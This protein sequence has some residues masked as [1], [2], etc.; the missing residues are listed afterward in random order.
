MYRHHHHLLEGKY[1][2]EERIEDLE[3]NLRNLIQ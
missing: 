1:L 3:E 2:E